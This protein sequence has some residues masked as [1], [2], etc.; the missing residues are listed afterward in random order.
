MWFGSVSKTRGSPMPPSLIK[1]DKPVP[2][3]SQDHHLSVIHRGILISIVLFAFGI[4]LYEVG[5]I[6][7]GFFV[8]EASIGY[9]AYSLG[10][11]GIDGNGVRFPLYINEIAG[12]QKNPVYIYAAI[13]PVKLF[14]LNETAVRGTSVFFG[15][16]AVIGVFWLMFELHGPIAGII[17]AALLSITPWHFHFSRIAFELISFP[18]LFILGFAFLI[19]AIKKGGWNWAAGAIMMG[20]TI[21]TYVMAVP[22]LPPFLLFFCV[23]YAPEIFKHRK[24]VLIS[25]LMFAIIVTPAIINRLN[26]KNTLHYRAAVWVSQDTQTAVKEKVLTFWNHYKAFF[27]YDFL[28]Q[29]GDMNPR[30]SVKNHGLLYPS[31]LP[32]LILSAPFLIFPFKRHSI[33]LLLWLGLFPFGA[34]LTTDLYAT[35]S[36]MG[37]PL[38]AIFISISVARLWIIIAGIRWRCVR[39]PTNALLLGLVFLP[40]IPESYRY[41]KIYFEKYSEMSAQGFN[42]FQYGYRQIIHFMEAHSEEYPQKMLTATDVN[43][44]DVYVNFYAQLNPVEF[45]RTKNTG[46]IV[47]RPFNYSAYNLDQPTIYALRE[48]ELHYFEDYTIK[49]TIIDPNGDIDFIVADVRKRKV[50][51]TEWSVIGVFERAA[52]D[53]C[54]ETYSFPFQT[55]GQERQGLNGV[56]HWKKLT[57]TYVNLEFQEFLQDSDP[58]HP[59]NPENCSAEA[60]TYIY[61]PEAQNGYLEF[62]GSNDYL[63][64]WVNGR[65]ILGSTAISGS[66]QRMSGLFQSGWNEIFVRSCEGLGDWY[67]AMTITDENGKSIPG[68]IQQATPPIEYRVIPETNR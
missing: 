10:G 2:Q 40:I 36:I 17:A 5:D 68:M 37:S 22:F 32:L 21:H 23:L 4:R 47:L 28:F 13:L 60:V 39:W 18:S 26:T 33:L 3:G 24:Y 15:T 45:S 48:Q 52:P 62:F 35:R 50:F 58:K 27:S 65:K 8:D 57:T 19:R 46:Y 12:V 20:L 59:K 55:F 11:W 38:A 9:H 41:F 56:V 34:A 1:T 14:G 61:L 67:L 7:A 25:V 31:F 64:I 43:Y 51:L 66:L 63:V 54:D 6:P 29:T 42:G 44:P 30:H 53:Q 16:L 49:D